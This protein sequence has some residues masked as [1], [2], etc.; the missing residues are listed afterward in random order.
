MEQTLDDIATGEAEW[1]PYLRQF[2][3][4]WSRNLVKRETRLT[5]HCRTVELEELDA[6]V[7]IGNWSLS[8]LTMAKALLLLQFPKI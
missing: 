5:K 2:L 8:K 7:R 1:L 4:H 6:R 3:G